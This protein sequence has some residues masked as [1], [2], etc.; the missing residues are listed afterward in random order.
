L[1]MIETGFEQR[2][3]FRFI[4]WK[5]GSD[6]IDVKTCTSDSANQFED[7]GSGERLAA[8]EVGVQHSE[9][10]GL[11]KNGRP[12]CCGKSVS[13]CGKLTWIGTVD[14]VQ[15]TAMR[16]YTNKREW[17]KSRHRVVGRQ[18]IVANPEAVS[19]SDGDVSAL[20]IHSENKAELGQIIRFAAKA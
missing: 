9:F 10:R 12:F 16:Q 15:R 7:V 2:I 17:G 13:T 20:R 18:T 6:Q 4:K 3:E 14:A 19:K 11:L 1:K 5:A 8:S